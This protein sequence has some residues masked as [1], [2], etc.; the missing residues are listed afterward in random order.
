MFNVTALFVVLIINSSYNYFDLFLS[1]K[2]WIYILYL[3][4]QTFDF[5][6][7][8]FLLRNVWQNKVRQ[9]INI[10]WSWLQDSNWLISI[11]SLMWSSQHC[12]FHL[13]VFRSNQFV[14]LPTFKLSVVWHS[15]QWESVSYKSTQE[16]TLA[17]VNVIYLGTDFNLRRILT[18][19]SH[20]SF[21]HQGKGGCPNF[22]SLICLLLMQK[23]FKQ[24]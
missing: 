11:P 6:F 10:T 20:C 13:F 3:Y 8:T 15:W 23:S 24:A 14:G 19:W 9:S 12:T 17:T 22:S 16:L 4:T 1:Q 2:Q 18:D 21:R 7:V 5:M